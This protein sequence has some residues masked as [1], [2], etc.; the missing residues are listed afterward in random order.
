LPDDQKPK[1]GDHKSSRI[2]AIGKKLFTVRHVREWISVFAVVGAFIA[3]ARYAHIARL[4]LDETIRSNR[5]AVVAFERSGKQTDDALKIAGDQARAMVTANAL[6]ERSINVAETSADAAKAAVAE[7]R[8]QAAF[9]REAFEKTE[10]AVLVQD[11]MTKITLA[12]GVKM[13]VEIEIRNVGKRPADTVRFGRDWGIGSE[14]PP[15]ICEWKPPGGW[16]PTGPTLSPGE[17]HKPRLEI[18][19]LTQEQVT[20][21]TAHTARLY[22]FGRIAY[23]D[24]FGHARCWC[25]CEYYSPD[26]GIWMFC[27]NN[28]GEQEHCDAK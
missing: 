20:A 1:Q 27:P 26:D 3:A 7:A 15:D 19:P 4:Q 5:E 9:G 2:R 25:F 16:A 8:K 11:G 14:L 24:G 6:T 12:V 28:N 13:P 21:I 18:G 17:P 10:R 23:R 22:V